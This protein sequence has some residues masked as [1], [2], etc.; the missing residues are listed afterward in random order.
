MLP[1]LPVRDLGRLGL[2]TRTLRSATCITVL[3]CNP[4]EGM[5]GF[6]IGHGTEKKDTKEIGAGLGSSAPEGQ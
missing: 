2:H 1:P 4:Q 6:G 5:S 3:H